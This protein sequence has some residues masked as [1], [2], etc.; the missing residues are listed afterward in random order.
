MSSL[1]PWRMPA[2][3]APVCEDQ[4]VSQDSRLKEPSRTQPASVGAFPLE[5]ARRS[6]SWARPSISRKTTP[7]H[8]GPG[9]LT[10]HLELT[11]D[12][13]QVPGAVFIYRQ[14]RGDKG[15]NGGEGQDQ[16]DGL[17]EAL[18][19]DPGEGEYN[20]GDDHRVQD[21]A[22]EPQGHDAD[23]QS[24]TGEHRPGVRSAG[25]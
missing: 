22:E 6:T 12:H 23:S 10:A 7:G 17:G 18:L 24:E 4:S 15:G 3:Q 19:V 2:W 20:G 13:V 9:H 14:Q 21:E 8:I 25:R 16:A 5:M 1:L 11:L